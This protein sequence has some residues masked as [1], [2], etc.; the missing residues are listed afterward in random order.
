MEPGVDRLGFAGEGQMGPIGSV[1]PRCGGSGDKVRLTIDNKGLMVHVF[2][3]MRCFELVGRC[4]FDG[5][6]WQAFS[7]SLPQILT[8][9]SFS[10]NPAIAKFMLLGKT[11][12]LL[13]HNN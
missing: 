5:K 10:H 11:P 9:H 4:R 7:F 6:L 2:V 8:S 1:D 13:F 12:S 3:A